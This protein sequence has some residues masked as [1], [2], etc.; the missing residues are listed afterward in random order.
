MDRARQQRHALGVYSTRLA[1]PCRGR[2]THVGSRTASIRSSS[3]ALDH[4]FAA[5][6]PRIAYALLRRAALD[7]TGLPP[8]PEEVDHFATDLSEGA[9]E[10]AVDRLLD[11]SSPHGEPL[12]AVW[13][14]LARYG[15]SPATFTTWP[16]IWKATGL[17]SSA[18]SMTT[19]RTTSS[20]PSCWP[21]TCCQRDRR[22][23]DRDR[24]HRNTTTNTEGGAN[25][26][27]YRFAAV[28][29]RVNTTS[30]VDGNDVWMCPMS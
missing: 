17:A 11:D 5:C 2:A 8:S 26:E 3:H 24:F 18:R 13:L 25:A 29:D 6:P 21:A 15:D 4:E 28:V 19:C 30:K 1:H 14:D 9:Y 12:A 20:R 27:E 16:T 10:R 23:A 22:A 7:L